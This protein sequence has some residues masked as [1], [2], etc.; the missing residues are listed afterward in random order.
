MFVFIYVLLSCLYYI[1]LHF[2][3]QGKQLLIEFKLIWGPKII[4]YHSMHYFLFG[5]ISHRPNLFFT[6]VYFAIFSLRK[7]AINIIFSYAGSNENAPQIPFFFFG[8]FPQYFMLTNSKYKQSTGLHWTPVRGH[9]SPTPA[10]LIVPAMPAISNNP[11]TSATMP[12]V[13]LPPHRQRPN[14]RTTSGALL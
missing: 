6:V 9:H 4:Y 7:A 3:P 14:Y 8:E 11:N 5:K 13:C 2:S 1:I 12:L 10:P